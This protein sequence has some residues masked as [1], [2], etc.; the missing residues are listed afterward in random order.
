MEARRLGARRLGTAVL[1]VLMGGSALVAQ[2]A[3]RTIT[4]GSYAS[5]AEVVQAMA[6]QRMGASNRAV[7]IL[8]TMTVSPAKTPLDLV[9]VSVEDLGLR[10]H[11]TFAAIAAAARKRGLELCPAEAGPLLRLEYTNQAE[12]NTLRIAMEPVATGD[13][14]APT[15]FMLSGNSLLATDSGIVFDKYIRWVF[16]RR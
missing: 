16:A 6:D 4:L 10:D 1:C 8:K 11:A 14:A 9:I 2:A 5:V 3:F 15:V 7:S 12:D 13:R